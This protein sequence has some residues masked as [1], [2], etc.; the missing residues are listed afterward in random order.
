[1]DADVAACHCW[2][3]LQGA[4][5]P[6]SVVLSDD[7]NRPYSRELAAFPAAWVRA[8]KFWPSTSRVDNVYGDRNL[9]CTVPA[10]PLP[11]AIAA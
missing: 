7:W 3:P 1:M 9:V 5:H 8:S 11:E 6:A 2:G 10:A 4:P